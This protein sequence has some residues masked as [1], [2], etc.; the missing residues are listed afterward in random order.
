MGS[1]W[2][3]TT[4]GDLCTFLAGSA[5]A[6]KYQG[7]ISGEYPFIKVSDMKLAGNERYINNAKNWVSESTRAKIG[8]KLHPKG[9]LAFAKI[10]VALT[11]NRRRLLTQATILDNNMMSAIP[12]TNIV[13]YL[14]FYY[15][16]KTI[17]FNEVVCGTSLPYLRTDDLKKIQIQ[18]PPLYK[19]RA[20]ANILGSLDDKLELNRKMNETLEEMAKAIFKSWFVDF[21]PVRA[22]AEGRDTGLPD[23]ISALFP[24][25]FEFSKKL[26][27][28]IPKGWVTVPVGDV[29]NLIMGQSPP[30]NTY[31]QEGEGIP[32]Y[33]GR[34]DFGFRFPVRRIYC[35]APKRIAEQFD[36]LVS[37]RAPVGD[38]N[39]ANE[40]CCIGRGLAALK[41]KSGS[42]SFSY[43]SMKN[44]ETI[45]KSYESGGTVFGSINKKEF[46]NL[47]F[48]EPVK[49]L[50]KAFDHYIASIDKIIFNN[51]IQINILQEL[52]DSLLQKLISGGI[53]V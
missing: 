44:L 34:T 43:Y 33:Q 50:V 29:F 20:I 28:S 52:R 6:K 14:Y 40:K 49:K 3:L 15:L 27:K 23:E 30:G 39:V 10:G 41:H 9:S 2:T 38:V 51:T 46:K 11:Y 8:A 45:F 17:D 19:Q 25:E 7:N 37:V 24:A 18:L 36:I 53:E 1:E 16:L 5:F 47:I 26:G 35:K 42:F 22:K 12:N 21:D 31:N 32:F 13:E 48:I 4:L